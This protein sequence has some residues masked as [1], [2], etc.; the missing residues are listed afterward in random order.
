VKVAKMDR[1]GISYYPDLLLLLPY[2]SFY[3]FLFAQLVGDMT[4][5]IERKK[6]EKY[7]QKGG[8]MAEMMI[9]PE[10]ANC[11]KNNN[12]NFSLSFAPL[13]AALHF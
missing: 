1:C 3:L 7:G 12:N 6:T 13:F 9:N 4:D 10:C 8:W 11:V 5:L 2:I